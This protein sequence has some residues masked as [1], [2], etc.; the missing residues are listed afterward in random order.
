MLWI[1]YT[2]F[3]VPVIDSIYL[4]WEKFENRLEKH[5]I[6]RIFIEW[7][8][9]IFRKIIDRALDHKTEKKHQFSVFFPWKSNKIQP[10]YHFIN[11]YF[12]HI[13]IIFSNQDQLFQYIQKK[14][15]NKIANSSFYVVLF[16]FIPF[17]HV[18]TWFV[19]SL[20][21]WSLSVSMS[22]SFSLLLLSSFAFE[23]LAARSNL[24]NRLP[25]ALVYWL[26]LIKNSFDWCSTAP[27]A[28]W[29]SHR[30]CNGRT[31]SSRN[32]SSFSKIAKASAAVSNVLRHPSIGCVRMTYVLVRDITSRTWR[33]V[34]NSG[35]VAYIP[36]ACG[37]VPSSNI[38]LNGPSDGSSSSIGIE[39]LLGYSS[40][41]FLAVI[42]DSNVT[43]ASMCRVW[44][45]RFPLFLQEKEILWVNWK[46]KYRK[47]II[48]KEIRLILEKK[49]GKN[50]SKAN[51]W[52]ILFQCP[53]MHWQI[54]VSVCLYTI[55]SK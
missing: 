33:M 49:I 7:K 24:P 17:N 47:K 51:F 1:W 41:V 25:T 16:I 46:H 6:S 42:M 2:L 35:D 11:I 31:N 44:G 12:I 53:K 38:K 37:H 50:Q 30:A 14:N 36:L 13:S 9:R 29:N 54:E 10:F 8:L 4:N 34:C 21:S 32:R 18:S 3:F 20:F 26:F 5:Q 43:S 28:N 22:R 45:K 55:T 19:C 52:M 48:M 23:Q 39:S 15:P 40:N 27:L